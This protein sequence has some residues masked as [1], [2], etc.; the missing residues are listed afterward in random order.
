MF[1]SALLMSYP[2]LSKRVGMEK[3]CLP[4]KHL[5][6][7]KCGLWEI[8]D[9]NSFSSG[10]KQKKQVY[11][12]FFFFQKKKKIAFLLTIANENYFN[13]CKIQ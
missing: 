13:L 3:L 2:L 9:I 7:P 11:I 5:N 8:L 6:T 12:F 10:E 4:G 1:F